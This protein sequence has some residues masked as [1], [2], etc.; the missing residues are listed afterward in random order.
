[1]QAVMLR[2][3]EKVAEW[4]GGDSDTFLHAQILFVSFPYAG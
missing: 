4:G 1:M 3:P 2:S